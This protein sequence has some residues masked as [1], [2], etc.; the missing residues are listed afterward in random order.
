MVPFVSGWEG[1]FDLLTSAEVTSAA[2]S[3]GT[4]PALAEGTILTEGTQP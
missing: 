2:K 1:K 3:V 4:G